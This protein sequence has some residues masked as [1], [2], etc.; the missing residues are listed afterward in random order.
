[1]LV[2]ES[3]AGRLRQTFPIID[4]T[5]SAPDESGRTVLNGELPQARERMRFYAIEREPDLIDEQTGEVIIPGASNGVRL[6]PNEWLINRHLRRLKE[7][8]DEEQVVSE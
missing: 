1:M 8:P 5:V 6:K 4:G 2:F 3:L 7:T